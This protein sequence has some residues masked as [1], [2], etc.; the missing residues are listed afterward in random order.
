MNGF[1]FRTETLFKEIPYSSLN[2]FFEERIWPLFVPLM[3]FDE[4]LFMD[5]KQVA[6]RFAHR[7]F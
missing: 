6:Y 3:I 2:R 7:L 4:C 5:A 1:P